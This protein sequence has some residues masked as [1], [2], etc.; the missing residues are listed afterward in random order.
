ML[1]KDLGECI[2]THRQDGVC[3][4]AWMRGFRGSRALVPDGTAMTVD[5][6]R[7]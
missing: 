6:L 3:I 4:A 7:P 2:F 5:T 1:K